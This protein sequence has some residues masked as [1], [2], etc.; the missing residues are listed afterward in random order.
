MIELRHLRHL[1]AVAE[2]GN[3]S[4]A[5]DAVHLTQPALS[6][7]IQALEAEIGAAVFERNRGAIEPTEIGRLLLRHAQ[8]LDA[9]TRDL[10]REIRLTKGLELGE[11]RI[12]VGPFGGSA[13]IGPVVG[14]LNRLHPRL[15]VKLTVAPW[16]ELPERARA[17]DVDLIVAEL[18]EIQSLEDFACRPLSEHPLLFVCRAG[19]PLTKLGEPR[20]HDAFAYPL[21]GPRLPPRA[22]KT[23]LSLMPARLREGVQRAG[24]LTIECDSSSVLKRILVESDAVS[25]MPRFMF[26]AE[27]GSGEL[28]ALEKIEFGLRAQFGAA[29]LQRRSMAGAGLK[30]IELLQ[31]HDA[32][33]AAMAVP[34]ARRR[35]TSAARGSR[36]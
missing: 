18:S 8:A 33:V 32:A 11:L 3:F 13:L 26:E 22:E 23:L 10:D 30:F 20:P 31:A 2:Q 4:R 34:P 36:P 28:I 29:W 1:L 6:R 35:R 12:G 17:R 9:S 19:H 15:R 25:N 27:V 7:S 16:Q 5:A 24:L 21:A 14:R